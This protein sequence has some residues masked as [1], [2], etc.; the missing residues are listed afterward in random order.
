MGSSERVGRCRTMCLKSPS[1][2]PCPRVETQILTARTFVTKGGAFT[3]RV[4]ADFSALPLRPRCVIGFARPSRPWVLD[5][6]FVT[7]KRMTIR[8]R[9]A[10]PHGT[11][12]SARQKQSLVLYF[13]LVSLRFAFSVSKLSFARFGSPRGALHYQTQLQSKSVAIHWFIGSVCS[14]SP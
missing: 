2:S 4:V 7:L 5:T 10:G 14:D 9:E 3:H 13:S 12:V 11:Y 8:I 6:R 1:N